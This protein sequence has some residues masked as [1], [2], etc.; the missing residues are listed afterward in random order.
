MDK[1]T[2]KEHEVQVTTRAAHDGGFIWIDM[3]DGELVGPLD[4]F[5]TRL[6]TANAAC[7]EG[8]EY[9]KSVIDGSTTPH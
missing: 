5:K 4:S 3:I 1:I 6:P 8:M 7:Q 2:Y 9:A